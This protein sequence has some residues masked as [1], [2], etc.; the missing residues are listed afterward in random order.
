MDFMAIDT[1]NQHPNSLIRLVGPYYGKYT[2]TNALKVSDIKLVRAI[3]DKIIL[4][5]KYG[6]DV[7]F[8]PDGIDEELLPH[9]ITLS[10]SSSSTISMRLSSSF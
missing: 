2:L 4:K 1:F 10:Y 3:R 5:T 6:V 7:Y 8:L 9:P